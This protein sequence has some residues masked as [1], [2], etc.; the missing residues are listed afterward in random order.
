M[1]FTDWY[2]ERRLLKEKQKDLKKYVRKTRKTLKSMADLHFMGPVPKIKLNKNRD[3]HKAGQASPVIKEEKLINSKIEIFGIDNVT[4][5]TVAHEVMHATRSY[6]AYKSNLKIHRKRFNRMYRR[7]GN[8]FVTSF[9]LSSSIQEAAA[10]FYEILYRRTLKLDK[11]SIYEDMINYLSDI[12][13]NNNANELINKSADEFINVLDGK[14]GEKDIGSGDLIGNISKSLFNFDYTLNWI[15][16][17]FIA[18]MILKI[19]ENDI[20]KAL[21]V[22]ISKND[23]VIVKLLIKNKEYVNDL[24]RT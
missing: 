23:L 21:R 11:K 9:I 18:Y 6:K 14:Y 22:L 2:R 4:E 7:Y 19:N 20:T 8:I 1:S 5:T 3:E 24:R 16:G 13:N 17:I 15:F 12:I 10:E